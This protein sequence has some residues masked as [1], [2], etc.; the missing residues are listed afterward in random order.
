VRFIFDWIAVYSWVAPPPTSSSTSMLTCG[1][2]PQI[3]GVNFTC[4]D[5]SWVS[6]P[7]AQAVISGNV[8]LQVPL[9]IVGNLSINSSSAHVSLV[10]G[11]AAAP[12]LTIT[13]VAEL[14]GAL[15]LTL[16]SN[17]TSTLTSGQKLY[18]GAASQGVIRNFDSVSLMTSESSCAD[19]RGVPTL[20]NTG[21]RFGV[22]LTSA[23]TRCASNLQVI[24]IVCVVA[25]AAVLL[26]AIAAV[27]LWK[28]RHHLRSLKRRAK[29]LVTSN[30]DQSS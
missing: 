26:I 14:R 11:D 27:L 17:L 21:T 6:N 8:S 22:L 12:T 18:V 4:T 10:I 5:G 25:A 20:D 2:N 1:P 23:S 7:G 15:T 30:G 29:R 3:P 28:N 9:T 16:G 13:G 19:V 24:I